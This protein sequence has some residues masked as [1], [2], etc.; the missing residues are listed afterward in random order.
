[1]HTP[2]L[3]GGSKLRVEGKKRGGGRGGPGA[4]DSMVEGHVRRR[5]ACARGRAG[6]NGTCLW[7]KSEIQKTKDVLK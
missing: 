3:L 2:G 1:M 6:Q 7:R 4:G 5:R